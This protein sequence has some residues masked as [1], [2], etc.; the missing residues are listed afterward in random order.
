MKLKDACFLEEKPWQTYNSILKSRGIT[1]LI[2]VC[3]VKA[4]VFSN[5]HIP[6]WELDHKE[7]WAP[8]N[9]CLQTVEKTL[10]SHLDCKEIKSVNPKENQS[11]ILI[12]RTD[13]EPETL[14]LWSP[15]ANSQ[16]IGKDSDAGKDWGQKEKRVT[17][18]EMDGWHHKING[19]ESEQTLGDGEGQ[20][21]LVCCSPWGCRVRHDLA[22]EQQQQDL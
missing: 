14:I 6:M 12:G 8:K 19:K 22:T 15:E 11:W 3:I 18:D 21:S 13:P 10:E 17:E 4:M 9:W 5:S 7:C 20:E 16:L 2:K 1:L